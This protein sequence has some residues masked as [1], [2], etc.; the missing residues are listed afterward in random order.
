MSLTINTN[1]MSLN[2]QKNLGQTQAPLQ[3]AMQ[4]LSSG[5]RVNSSKDD[6][7]G[8]AIATRMTMQ[9]NGLAQSQRN[10]NDGISF[11]QTAES[12]MDEMIN[13]VQRMYELAQQA[14][15]YNTSA[16]RSSLNQEV[17][18]L[19][20]EL[21]RI[22]N[23]T[24]YNGEQFMNQ[25]KSIDIQ[26]GTNVNETI[27]ISTS[28]LSPNTMG[29]ATSYSN[30]LAG[31]DIAKSGALTY[32]AT[33]MSASATLKGVSLGAAI[34]AASDFKN[35]S[36]NLI[37]RI[38]TYTGDTGVTAFS[39]GNSLVGGSAAVTVANDAIT[40]VGAGFMTINGTQIA[41]FAVTSVSTASLQNMLTSIND[42]SATTG[43]TGYFMDAGDFEVSSTAS[44]SSIL[45]LAN[46]NGAAIDVSLNSSV[47]GGTHI[48]GAAGV[49]ASAT[50]S[51]AA[52]QNGKI[53][54][55]DAFTNTS[56]SF[57]GTATG[58]V[59]GV[60]S[61]SSSVSLTATSINNINVNTAASANIALLA[62]QKS[63][64]IFTT[65]KA[66]LGAVLNRFDSV[67]RSVQN[68]SENIVAAKS[69][70]MDADFAT[71]TAKMT[72]SLILQQA[73][74]SV[75]AQANQVP[76]NVLALLR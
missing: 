56:V 18:Q 38:N 48:S 17:S 33:G 72:K 52:G 10:A 64:D 31:S 30:S 45:V 14:A 4:R 62:A 60:G 22:V 39:F 15:S 47:A 3:Q 46:T 49:L 63:L 73:G 40:S 24:R 75:L 9:I 6:A 36:L 68:T 27:N 66:K 34:S 8:L 23:Q 44:A 61:S 51:V 76:N 54:F 55:N 43:V 26:V 2:A 1:L 57:D 42:Q 41:S 74:I 71:E 12:A 20:A 7:A 25:Q 29:V 5:L 19:Q 50:M 21:S 65:Q 69:R 67:I 37:N 53:I 32:L 35:N 28:N 11:A 59:M 70:I 58:A 16:D 13:G